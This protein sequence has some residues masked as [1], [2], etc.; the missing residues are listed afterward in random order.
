MSNFLR[1]YNLTL[2]YVAGLTILGFIGYYSMEFPI[3]KASSIGTLYGFMVGVVLNIIPAFFVALKLKKE[4]TSPKKT[5]SK[6]Q[7]RQ[8]KKEH[9]NVHQKPLSSSFIKEMY[10]L[11]DKE[12]AFDVALQSILNQSLGTLLNTNKH[13][14]AFSVRTAHQTIDFEIQPL[15]R[16]TSKVNIKA[17]KQN[18]TF[19]D[20]LKYIKEKEASV[21]TY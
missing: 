16:H 3:A 6:S 12:M 10:L 7:K 21:L 15:T 11:L 1:A 13:R 5:V 9:T 18:D 8:P 2:I 17:Q 4:T 14:G 19:K 20:I